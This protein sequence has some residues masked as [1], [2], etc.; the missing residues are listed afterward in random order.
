M[1]INGMREFFATIAPL[2]GAADVRSN[3]FLSALPALAQQER[4]AHDSL[5]LSDIGK[6]LSVTVRESSSLIET[7]DAELTEIASLPPWA[8][9]ADKAMAKA[10]DVLKRMQKLAI[11]AQNKELSDIDRVEMQIEIE[12]LRGNLKAIPMNLRGVTHPSTLPRH[13]DW[14][15]YGYGDYSSVLGRMRERI[16]NGQE[17][18]VRE[19]WCPEGFTRVTYDENGEEVWEI[20][21]ANAWHVVDD[22][23]M[24]T[25]LDGKNVDSGRKVL[26]VREKL[27]WETPVIVMDAES[28]AKGA[29]FLEQQITSVQKWREQLPES[30][31]N[32]SMEHAI[33]F[34]QRIAIPDG[35]NREPLTDPTR[36]SKF[37]FS[38]GTYDYRYAMRN[39]FLE[40]D[41]SNP[42]TEGEVLRNHV[43]AMGW[44]NQN[45]NIRILWHSGS[46][47][48][49]REEF[50]TTVPPEDAEVLYVKGVG[51]LTK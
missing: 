27:E 25:F 34:L 3:T 14:G 18:N 1:Q 17:W 26:T 46:S 33:A 19:A 41:G 21:E 35:V 51:S 16:L 29:M 38:D 49:L 42:L 4:P 13:V 6:K 23:N 2:N 43:V 8:Q 44:F 45:A 20:G 37:L 10:I 28:A 15:D 32:L 39:S 30:L 47:Q 40:S 12:D 7:R 31:D 11:A 50:V 24:L 48:K 9:Q 36:A 22:K 5:F